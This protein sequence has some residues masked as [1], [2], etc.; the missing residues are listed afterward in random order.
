MG[1]ASALS[2]SVR[3]AVREAAPR[4]I[5]AWSALRAALWPDQDAEVMAR[6]AREYFE[7]MRKS[8]A[9]IAF[10][11]NDI[12]VGFAEATIRNDYVNGT[13]A[14]PVGFLEGL[15]VTPEYRRSGLGRALV[16]AVERWTRDQGCNEL[17]SDAYIDNDES[18]AAHRAYGFV[19]TE[20]VV[21]FCKRLAKR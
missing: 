8:I 17:A 14:S 13:E 7:P 20:R 16:A 9:L 12:A 10:D 3:C 5:A 4:D 6:E 1:E 19:E 18:H 2:V 15:Y 11:T 21:Y